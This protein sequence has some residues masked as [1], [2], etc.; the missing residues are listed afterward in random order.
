MNIKATKFWISGGFASWLYTAR[1]KFGDFED[2]LNEYIT[3]PDRFLDENRIVYESPTFSLENRNLTITSSGTIVLS[4]IFYTDEV[5]QPTQT[6]SKS[7]SMT[8]T[9][10]ELSTESPTKLPTETQSKLQTEIPTKLKTESNSKLQ[11]EIQSKS[12]QIS[13]IESVTFSNDYEYSTIRSSEMSELWISSQFEGTQNSDSD[14]VGSNKDK[15]KNKFATKEA[16][17]F[18]VIASE[19]L[20][21]IVI[22]IVLLVI[23]IRTRANT[24]QRFVEIP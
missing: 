14:F 22:I 6:S 12:N 19:M 1:I 10:T 17:C 13:N 5:P 8:P 7:P 21:I 18:I 15:K 2:Y 3:Y 20:I 4:C 24:S 23:I 9:Q 11:T 16:I